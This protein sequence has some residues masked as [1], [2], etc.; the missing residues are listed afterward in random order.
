MHKRAY[1]SVS[2]LL[3]LTREFPLWHELVELAA[4]TTRLS[5]LQIHT[6]A[7]THACMPS[8]HRAPAGPATGGGAND[9]RRG[10]I[11]VVQA[12]AGEDELGRLGRDPSEKGKDKK[13]KKKVPARYHLV[14]FFCL[15]PC[16]CTCSYLA[17]HFVPSPSCSGACAQPLS[18]AQGVPAVTG[19]NTVCG[20]CIMLWLC[21]IISSSSCWFCS[22]AFT[23]LLRDSENFI[24]AL[25]HISMHVSTGNLQLQGFHTL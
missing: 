2:T 9:S 21:F 13:D 23:A 12:R 17:Y 1:A 11:C 20:F 16:A 7:C 3:G 24:I 4:S 19:C 5:C 10:D 8:L 15:Q 18:C 22:S 6:H 25:E 14:L